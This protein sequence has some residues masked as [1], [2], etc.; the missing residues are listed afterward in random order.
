MVADLV[1]AALHMALFTR[2]PG[3]TGPGVIHQSDQDSQCTSVAFGKRCE[4]MS[5][6]TQ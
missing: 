2:N 3:T 6:R 4:E 5:V 1:V